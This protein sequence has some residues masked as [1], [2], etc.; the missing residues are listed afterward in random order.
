M[1]DYFRLFLA[2][3][4]LIF[5]PL[6]RFA[7]KILPLGKLLGYVQERVNGKQE[8]SKTVSTIQHLKNT[9]DFIAFRGFPFEPHFVTTE[10]GYILGL[11]RIP[12]VKRGDHTNRPVVL[13]WHGFLMCSEVW[14]CTPDVK[15]SLAFTLARA[16]YDVWL[17]TSF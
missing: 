3:T 12:A 15:L 1:T 9:G 13:L 17:G 11:H 8:P 7:F 5:E 6:F 14:V 16:G 4:I 10:D 2:F